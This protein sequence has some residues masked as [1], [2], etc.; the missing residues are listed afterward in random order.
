[1]GHQTLHEHYK[2]EELS[3]IDGGIILSIVTVLLV[4]VQL[5]EKLKF[6]NGDYST[7]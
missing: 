4:Q 6:W 2:E 3:V 7:V 1:M 5:E